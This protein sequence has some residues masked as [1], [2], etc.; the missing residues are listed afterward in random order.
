MPFNA[1]ASTSGSRADREG[2][3]ELEALEF[4][5]QSGEPVAGDFNGDGFTDLLIYRPQTGLSDLWWSNGDRSFSYEDDRPLPENAT[6]VVGNF[7][8]RYGDD[9]LFY[10]PGAGADQ[11]FWSVGTG[12]RLFTSTSVSVGG[13]FTAFSADH[14]ANGGDD[15]FLYDPSTGSLEV[16]WSKKNGSFRT[17]PPFATGLLNYRPMAGNFDGAAGDD[18]FW[19][20]P[21]SGA[22]NDERASWSSTNSQRLS[23][24]PVQT[25]TSN[26]GL[27]FTGDFDGD[28]F[29]DIFWDS[30]G[31]SND[32]IWRGQP[33]RTFKSVRSSAYGT[34]K[35]AAGRFDSNLTADV[36]WYRL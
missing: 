33:D 17:A 9:F 23:V 18:V 16:W 24:S 12:S 34:F 25:V 2:Q 19:Y 27:S 15:L 28:G 22:G 7:D 35:A 13:A 1:R 29:E 14:D 5:S 32:F 26:Y 21:G 8:G 31:H 30:V 3:V 36:L 11:L 20:R 4:T 10:R 6:V